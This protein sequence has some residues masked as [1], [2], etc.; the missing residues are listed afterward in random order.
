MSAI[1]HRLLLPLLLLLAPGCL[2]TGTWVPLDNG[3]I[4]ATQLDEGAGGDVT[5]GDALGV[6]VDGSF[7]YEEIVNFKT[8]RNT[9]LGGSDLVLVSLQ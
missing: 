1:T 5:P 4:D 9:I 6:A 7:A 3:G 2:D 8:E